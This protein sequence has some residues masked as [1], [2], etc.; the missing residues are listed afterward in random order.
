MKGASEDHHEALGTIVEQVATIMDADGSGTISENEFVNAASL[1]A[2]FVGGDSLFDNPD[3]LMNVLDADGSGEVTAAELSR[4]VC[5][6]GPKSMP[7]EVRDAIAADILK[8]GDSNGRSAK[9]RDYQ[10][11]RRLIC[12]S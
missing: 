5:I 12:S 3:I 11:C 2:N 8:D 6:L 9:R 7:K 10:S 4:L 1:I